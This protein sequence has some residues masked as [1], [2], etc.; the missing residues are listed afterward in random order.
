MDRVWG[1][2]DRNTHLLGTV[3]ET[4]GKG[5]V[6][7][8][9]RL[10]TGA[11]LDPTVSELAVEDA[12]VAVGFGAVVG[13]GH[14]EAVARHLRLD[15]RVVWHGGDGDCD[16]CVWKERIRFFNILSPS[17]RPCWQMLADLARR[18]GSFCPGPAAEC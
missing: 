7:R 13:H 17:R 5:G 6:G 4:L 18:T 11:E 9:A 1:R 15:G 10:G 3:L 2:G 8:R 16:C 12:C 14:G